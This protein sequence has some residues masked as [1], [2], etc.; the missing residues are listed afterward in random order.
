MS[1]R[2]EI[3]EQANAVRRILA[4]NRGSMENVRSL[5]RDDV[6]HCVIAARGTSDNAA[7][8]AQYVWGARNGLTV[9]LATPSLYSLYHTPPSLTGSLV[10]GISQSG[11]SPDLV[12]V[13]D[14]ARQQDRPTIA[15]T[16]QPKSPLAEQAGAVIDISAG[17]ENAVAATKTY[18]TQLTAVALISN[19]LS[20][21]NQDPLD[22]LPGLIGHVL[23]Q[24]GQIAETVEHIVDADRCVV[25][26]RGY[27]FATAHEWALKL[28]E[29]TYMFAQPYS[30]ADFLHGPSAA[31]DADTPVLLAVSD[32]PALPSIVDVVKTLRDRGIRVIAISNTPDVPADQIIAIPKTKEW[33][34]PIVAAPALQLHSYHLSNASGQDPDHP[35]GLSKITRTR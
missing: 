35:R 30:T 23:H 3:L 15:I 12:A 13:L 6:T 5:L 33:L 28:Q 11:E 14:E 32:G 34:S 16:N 4:A 31:V 26:G 24:E 1:M 10:I 2:T 19:A 22:E 20:R 21:T 17:D 8:Y 27:H 29:T 25:L 18:T 7:R 9:G